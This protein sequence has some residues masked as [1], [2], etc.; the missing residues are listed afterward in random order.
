MQAIF[1]FIL[2][3][4]INLGIN[5]MKVILII[6]LICV[7]R[8]PLLAQTIF[9]EA[10]SF[11]NAGGWVI[12]QQSMDQMGSPY[13]LAHGLG[14]PVENAVTLI[15]VPAKGEYRI[16]VRTR[17]WVAPWGKPG[18]PGKFQLLINK[19]P[20]KTIFGTEGAEWHWQDG[21]TFNHGERKS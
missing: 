21:G 10:E 11:S 15:D 19:N 18:S 7:G 8:L 1:Y 4:S 16:W 20:L 5:I 14:V 6:F 13:L 17:D 3:K 12:D 2:V 9:I